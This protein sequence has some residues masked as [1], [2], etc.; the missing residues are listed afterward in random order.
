[1][2]KKGGKKEEDQNDDNYRRRPIDNTS[3]DAWRSM[4]EVASARPV[5]PSGKRLF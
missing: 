5:S 1:M 3:L 2:K 4:S